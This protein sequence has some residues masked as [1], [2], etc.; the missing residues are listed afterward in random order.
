MWP[1][2][3][4]AL[5]C[6]RKH[7]RPTLS[8]HPCFRAHPQVD[9]R[10]QDLSWERFLGAVPEPTSITAHVVDAAEITNILFSSGTTGWC[11]CLSCAGACCRP[12]GGLRW[13][14]TALDGNPSSSGCT[15]HHCGATL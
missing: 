5:A 2:M 7:P 11:L 8:R 15:A 9:L 14:P 4:I 6:V 3:C 13:H 1:R 10:R 12:A